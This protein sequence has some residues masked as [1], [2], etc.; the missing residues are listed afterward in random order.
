M[1]NFLML[2]SSKNT[3]FS[4]S[5][6][7]KNNTGLIKLISYRI[8][9]VVILLLIFNI[10][11]SYSQFDSSTIKIGPEDLNAVKGGNYF[12]FADK[13]KV[14]I[15]VTV[16]GGNG[17]GKYLIPV[18]TTVFD[19]LIMS[20]GTG[21]RNVDF[22]KLLRFSSETPQLKPNEI[23]DLD[24]SKLYSTENK[25]ILSS[26]LNPILKPGDMLVV[27]QPKT[28]PQSFWYYL[29]TIMSYITTIISFYY[30]VSNV[31]RY[32]RAF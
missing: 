15:E 9:I 18:G 3:L 21:R 31:F 10:N 16:I 23:I 5:D 24:F 7:Y 29:T 2:K 6:I 22:I 30:V 28:D 14:N 32:G 12:N 19:L 1:L 25:D 17:T 27:P 26:Q 11:N 13:N 4:K 8:S 20:G